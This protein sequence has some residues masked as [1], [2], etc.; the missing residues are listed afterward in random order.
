MKYFVLSIIFFFTQIAFGQKTNIDS[1]IHIS[2][3][4]KDDSTKSQTFFK[5]AQAY[6]LERI[7]FV[8][9]TIFAQKS[10]DLSNKIQYYSGAV[11][12][13]LLIGQTFREQSLY[14]EAIETFKSATRVCEEH[15]EQLSDRSLCFNYIAAYTL[16]TDMYV[17]LRDFPN[18][19]KNAFK[20][21]EIAEKYNTQRGK[22]WMALGNIFS[23]QKNI[24]EARK[25]TIKALE[26]FN[27][28]TNRHSDVARAYA[29]LARYYFVEG[30][31]QSATTTY[32]QSYETYKKINNVYGIRVALYN[33]AEISIQLKEYSKAEN[34]IAEILKNTN[35]AKDAMLLSFI[36]KLKF[37]LTL[38][39]KNYPEALTIC[40]EILDYAIKEKNIVDIKAAYEKYYQVYKETKDTIN[41]FLMIEKIS[42]LKDSIYNT[43]IV[44]NTAELVK[45]YETE[46]KEQQISFLNKENKINKEKLDKETQLRILLKSENLLK[47]S[48]LQQELLLKEALERENKLQDLE[49]E[50]KKTIQQVLERENKLKITELNKET[51]LSKTLQAQNGLMLENSKNETR[52]RWLMIAA[53]LGFIAFGINYYRSYKR[54]KSDNLQIVKQA[55]DLK[56]LMKEVHHRVKNNLQLIV[57]MLRMQH[58]AIEDK[59][60]VDA[61]VNSENRL[62]AIAVVHEKLYQSENISSVLLKD[63]LQ[64][65]IDVLAVQYHNA[66]KPIQFKIVDYTKLSTTLDTAIPVGL[67][68][69]ELVTNSLK[70]AFTDL[71]KGKIHL[72]ISRIDNKYQLSIQDNGK[73]LPNGQFPENPNTLGLR[74]VNL[75][76]DQLNGSLQYSNN[77]GACFT[78]LFS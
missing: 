73:G 32:L 72:E 78:I 57:A 71:E 50:Q 13:I 51:Q 16:I 64:E 42:E 49:I 62:H 67:I 76:T 41:A 38:Q 4:I 39:K 40:K 52:V 12:A 27:Q 15:K 58:R 33:L 48:K 53:L 36:N 26:D 11:S 66:S 23:E 77:E 63:Y 45:K 30:D 54:Q 8:S 28:Q 31:Y 29:F 37:S 47:E 74:L 25:Y 20:A 56:V 9:A 1:L 75:F 70:Y 61:L 6:K 7:D 22:C 3:T 35:A 65:L 69:N 34:Y 60:A 59:A 18:A 14:K 21:L 68:V 55:D 5:I 10:I 43:S 19:E 2:Q 46:K 17:V 24:A 44:N